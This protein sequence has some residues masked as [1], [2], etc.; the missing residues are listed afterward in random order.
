MRAGGG[1]G[2]GV[3]VWRRLCMDFETAAWIPPSIDG[4]VVASRA[5]D[6]RLHHILFEKKQQKLCGHTAT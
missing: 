6:H 5:L 3:G 2:G 1:G 4:V